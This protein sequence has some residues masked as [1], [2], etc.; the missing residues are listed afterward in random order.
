HTASGE[1]PSYRNASRTLRQGLE[2]SVA[3]RF[4]PQWTFHTAAT[5]LRAVY[6]QGFAAVV[7]GSRLP[8]VPNASFFGEL[9]WQ[10][11]PAVAGMG[12]G[13]AL[14]L[15]ANGRIYA[16]DANADMPAP[17]YALANLAFDA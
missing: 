2:L 12:W 10:P 6:T 4:N 13:A 7:A 11:P 9:K 17:G 8:G 14:E 3:A 1:R 15:Q 5:L 16:D